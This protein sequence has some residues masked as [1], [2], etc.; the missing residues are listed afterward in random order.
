[1][2]ISLR[3]ASNAGGNAADGATDIPDGAILADE[4]DFCVVLLGDAG[5]WMREYGNAGMRECRMQFVWYRS[6]YPAQ[7]RDATWVEMG[8][9]QEQYV[10]IIEVQVCSGGAGAG[11]DRHAIYFGNKQPCSQQGK[12]SKCLKCVPKICVRKLSL[13]WDYGLGCR[14]IGL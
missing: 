14:H 3:D 13:H 9:I 4:I 12:Q 1:M 5:S 8:E 10:Y 11:N 7:T 6:G 2:T